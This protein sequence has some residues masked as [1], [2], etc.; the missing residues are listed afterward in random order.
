[1]RPNRLRELWNAGKPVLNGWC[2]LPDSISAEVMAHQGWDSVSVDLQHSAVSEA[3]AIT[4]LQAIST[5]D[6][7]PLVRTPWNEPGVIMRLLDAGAYGVICPMVNNRA[8]A[9][10]FVAACRYP[11]DGIRSNGPYRALMYGGGDYQAHANAE[12]V[13]L[14]MIETREAMANLDLQE[15]AVDQSRDLR[16]NRRELLAVDEIRLR[17]NDEP[18]L[19]AE[20]TRNVEMLHRLRHHAFVGRDA[21]HD[22]VEPRGAADHRADEILVARHVDEIHDPCFGLEEREAE[23]DREPPLALFLETIRF[24][25]GER[26]DERRLPVID[27]ADHAERQ[28]ASHDSAA[29]TAPISI[30]V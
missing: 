1:M 5:T 6:A 18:S 13:T 19:D 23:H 11:P 20:Q 22:P 12:I 3:A 2:Q 4:M 7:V 15:R 24:D 17:H 30:C 27:V 26:A 25:A 29:R 14:A 9:E 10:A 16:L 8:D 21:Q 28:G